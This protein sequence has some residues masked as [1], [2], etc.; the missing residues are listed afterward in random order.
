M[1]VSLPVNIEAAR[2][3]NGPQIQVI[4]PQ[5]FGMWN[6][7]MEHF[8][9]QSIIHE[10]QQLIDMQMDE[11]S[12]TLVEMDGS[13]EIKNNQRNVLSLTLSNYAYHYHAAHGMTY[14]KSLTFDLDKRTRCSLEDLFKPGSNYV[15][16][17]SELIN[18][19]IQERNIDTFE[20]T[21]TIQPDQDFYI[22]DK[23]LV[24]Y[25]QLYEITPYVYGFPMFPISVYE[26]ED[27]INED[28]ALAPML[29]N[30]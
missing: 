16:R 3:S 10:A 27:I 29:M 7:S 24:I 6:Q 14:L 28:S 25:F 22:A 5:V 15:E 19:Q 23:T 26:I 17:L 9:N 30:N 13:F 20:D 4:Y 8:I 12:T 18:E 2:I 1:P 21:V 11:M